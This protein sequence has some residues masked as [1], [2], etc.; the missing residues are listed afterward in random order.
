MPGIY[1]PT[2]DGQD[3]QAVLLAVVMKLETKRHS[4]A[5]HATDISRKPFSHDYIRCPLGLTQCSTS[6]IHH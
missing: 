1:L 5:Y 4:R 6:S 3:E 2:W